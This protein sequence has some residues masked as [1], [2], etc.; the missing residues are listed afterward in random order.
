MTSRADS[1]QLSLLVGR[2]EIQHVLVARLPGPLGEGLDHLERLLV[3][4]QSIRLE[5]FDLD[6]Q[7]ENASMTV[8]LAR[9][10]DLARD[11]DV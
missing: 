1:L 7:T 9:A 11:S 6:D 10:M 2:G 5:L 8:Q 4:Y 3:L